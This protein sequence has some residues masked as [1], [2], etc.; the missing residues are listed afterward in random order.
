MSGQYEIQYWCNTLQ[1]LKL[2][3]LLMFQAELIYLMPHCSISQENRCTT[4]SC[5]L[6]SSHRIFYF[7]FVLHTTFRSLLL[8]FT[9]FH[10]YMTQKMRILNHFIRSTEIYTLRIN[11]SKY[12]CIGEISHC[13]RESRRGTNSFC[14]TQMNNKC[15]ETTWNTK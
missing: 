13:W 5:K 14:L 2:T 6:I 9:L 3:I 8:C 11:F 7:D 1:S 15:A 4:F 10:V 12:K